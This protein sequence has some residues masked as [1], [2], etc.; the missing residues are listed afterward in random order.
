[1]PTFFVGH[2]GVDESPPLGAE[3]K[4]K[5]KTGKHALT[6]RLYWPRS[7]QEMKKHHV[8]LHSEHGVSIDLTSARSALM[9]ILWRFHKVLRFRLLLLKTSVNVAFY[10]ISFRGNQSYT[11]RIKKSSAA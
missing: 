11:H 8:P 5:S 1:M 9:E 10:V 6:K 7:L 3:R 4:M 2:E